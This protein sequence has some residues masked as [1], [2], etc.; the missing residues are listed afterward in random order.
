[1]NKLPDIN[2]AL[3]AQLSYLKWNN[4]HKDKIKEVFLRDILFDTQILSQIKTDFYNAPEH[5]PSNESI[6]I[7]QENENSKI[8]GKLSPYVYHGEDKRLLLVY[9]LDEGKRPKA[10]FGE[11]LNGWEYLDC[12]TGE[13]IENKFFDKNLLE[14]YKESGFFGV[15]FQR[16]DDII[17]AY[18]GTETEELNKDGGT[19]LNI[20]FKQLDIQQVEAVLFYEY[21]K[22][23]YG[24]EN[25]KNKKIYITGHSLAG[26]LAQYVHLYATWQEHE[27]GHTVTWNGL[28]TFGSALTPLQFSMTEDIRISPN[29]SLIDVTEKLR[30]EQKKFRARIES[31]EKEDY[32]ERL[33]KFYSLT[34]KELREYIKDNCNNF[35]ENITN[36]YMHEDF[37]GGYLNGDYIGRK[38]AVDIEN[39]KDKNCRNHKNS[40]NE[41]EK[42]IE[43]IKNAIPVLIL[44]NGLFS[45]EKVSLKNK[46]ILTKIGYVYLVSSV[47][48]PREKFGMLID[49]VDKAK[50]SYFIEKLKTMD[51]SEISDYGK[52]MIVLLLN[53][54]DEDEFSKN[55]K[56]SLAELRR[57]IEKIFPPVEKGLSS[58][59]FHGVNNFLA[60]MNDSGNIEVGVMRK[61]FRW[62]A[63]KTIVQLKSDFNYKFLKG[64]DRNNKKDQILEIKNYNVEQEIYQRANRLIYGGI[65]V[66]F[67]ITQT[68]ILF[69]ENFILENFTAKDMDVNKNKPDGKYIGEI[70][71]GI[72]NN[73]ARLGGIHGQSP[74]KIKIYAVGLEEVK[75]KEDKKKVITFGIEEKE[76]SY[77]KV[78]R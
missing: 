39:K 74:V 30:E 75:V 51:I 46:G 20:Y 66:P 73:I 76:H 56:E 4:I 77:N 63:L 7:N 11:I 14:G 72:Y 47:L 40:E 65:F 28:G 68:D 13:M 12:A 29:D 33:K 1:M 25:G 23:K 50:I 2:Y 58:Y 60:F 21:I 8:E 57:Y 15:A 24:K 48:L 69:R 31:I 62:N 64:I 10:K 37:V 55:C 42:L 22:R 32:G 53:F 44:L 17:I 19:D 6:Y 45:D 5:F 34:V 67:P 9:S 70:T 78:L 3:M 54:L 61:E 59:I 41:K 35:R 38:V 18:R 16:G 71:L 52:D 27:I 43:N 26:A 36:Y 49:E